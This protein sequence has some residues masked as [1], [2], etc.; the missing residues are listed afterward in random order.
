MRDQCMNDLLVTLIEKEL[1]K[2]VDN[3]I[4]MQRFQTVKTRRGKLSSLT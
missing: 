3:E 2:R 1:F 4:I